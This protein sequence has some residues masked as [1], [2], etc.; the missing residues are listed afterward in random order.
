[1]YFKKTHSD[2]KFEQLPLIKKQTDNQVVATKVV[3]NTLKA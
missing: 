1:M 3:T 2:I